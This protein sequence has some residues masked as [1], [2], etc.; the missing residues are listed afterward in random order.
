MSYYKDCFSN[1]PI[2]LKKQEE[3]LETLDSP[4]WRKPFD[5]AEFNKQKDSEKDSVMSEKK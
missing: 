1:R 5:I 3:I 2:W 4:S